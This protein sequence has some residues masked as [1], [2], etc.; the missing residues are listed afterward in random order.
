MWG[1][2]ES[3]FAVC[4]EPEIVKNPVFAFFAPRVARY[5]LNHPQT[6]PGCSSGTHSA[7]P[8]PSTCLWLGM[9]LCGGR[10]LP[11][12][13]KIGDFGFFRSTGGPGEFAG[14]GRTGISPQNTPAEPCRL[15]R[16]PENRC[17]PDIC[18]KTAE[19]DVIQP[20]PQEA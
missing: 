14:G 16:A 13:T 7:A 17:S 9:V 6:R 20:T 2:T 3:W 19:S 15:C 5:P 11:E 12:S 4:T 1:T 18:R 10:A 8:L